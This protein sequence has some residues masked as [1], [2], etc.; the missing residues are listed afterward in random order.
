MGEQKILVKLMTYLGLS[1]KTILE[2]T[3]FIYSLMIC[4]LSSH[5]SK[6][7]VGETNINLIYCLQL[8]R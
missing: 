8:L 1:F 6:S 5:N 2:H 7:M 3:N 4:D